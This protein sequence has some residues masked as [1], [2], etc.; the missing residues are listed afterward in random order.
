MSVHHPN[1]ELNFRTVMSFQAEW[2]VVPIID[3]YLFYADEYVLPETSEDYENVPE[4]ASLQSSDSGIYA[5]LITSM[6]DEC[7]CV[8]DINL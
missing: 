1:S 4:A 8:D 3:I 7:K 5:P 6:M 2:T